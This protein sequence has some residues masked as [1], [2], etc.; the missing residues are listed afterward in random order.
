[1]SCNNDLLWMSNKRNQSPSTHQ[2][3]NIMG[4]STDRRGITSFSPDNTDTELCIPCYN[5]ISMISIIDQAK[6]YFGDRF[7][8]ERIEI[9]PRYIHT[10]CIGYDEYDPGDYTNYLVV[11]ICLMK[12]APQW[13]AL[14]LCG[15]NISSIGFYGLLSAVKALIEA[16]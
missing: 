9:E 2:K 4:Y 3:E 16:F 11:S 7:D 13:G 14:F 10:N 6:T 15:Y 5:P 1:M 8:M 12:R